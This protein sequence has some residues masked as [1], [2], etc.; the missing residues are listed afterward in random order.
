MLRP[1]RK[2][3]RCREAESNDP[4]ASISQEERGHRSPRPFT[5]G[6]MAAH[7][8]KPFAGNSNC[9]IG[10][11]HVPSLVKR[12]HVLQASTAK[13]PQPRQ[14]SLQSFTNTVYNPCA[15]IPLTR[16]DQNEPHNA[17]VKRELFLIDPT[18]S[19]CLTLQDRSLDDRNRVRQFGRILLF[20]FNPIIHTQRLL[21]PAT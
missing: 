8:G 4:I 5:P 11:K 1:K 2:R 7:R 19:T 21:T 6:L 16:I 12:A 9:R 14:L 10:L 13:A 3:S 15:P 20:Y 18:R 17:I